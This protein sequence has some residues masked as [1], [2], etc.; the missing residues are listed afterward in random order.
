MLMNIQALYN[1]AASN[2]IKAAFFARKDLVIPVITEKTRAL[3]FGDEDKKTESSTDN[4]QAGEIIKTILLS[5]LSFG[6]KLSL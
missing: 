1:F 6:V 4:S 3:F 5:G 2:S